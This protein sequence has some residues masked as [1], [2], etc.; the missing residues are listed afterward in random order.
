MTKIGALPII[1]LMV[2]SF[3]F[4]DPPD[5]KELY[6]RSLHS[7]K[8]TMAILRANNGYV[9]VVAD[10]CT[11]DFEEGADPGGGG[12]YV[13]LTFSY[14]WPPGTEWIM[15]YIDGTVRKNEGDTAEFTWDVTWD[16]WFPPCEGDEYDVSMPCADE[17]YVEAGTTIVIQWNNY[18]GVMIREELTP[19]SLGPIPGALEQ[20]RCKIVMKPVDGSCHSLGAAVYYDTQ[21]NGNDGA[22]ISTASGYVG[23][24]EIFYAPDIP[25][26]WRA[27]ETGYPPAPGSIVALGILVGFEA[28]MP[29]VF[30]YGPWR[31]AYGV[32]D[33]SHKLGWD[34]TG[35]QNMATDHE[36]FHD[37]TAVLVRWNERTVCPPDSVVFVTYYGI[38]GEL[39]TYVYFTH[40]PPEFT[41]HCSEI[42]PNPATLTFM[43]TNGSSTD[44]H[45]VCLDLSLPA[46]MT[47]VGGD[48]DPACFG[49]IAGYGGTQTVEWDVQ[50]DPSL[51]GTTVCY[52]VHLFYDEGPDSTATYCVDIPEPTSPVLTMPPDQ[53]IC[54]GECVGLTPTVS[55]GTPPYSFLWTPAEGLSC[56][57]CQYPNACPESTTTYQLIVTDAEGCA[58]TRTVTVYVSRAADIEFVYPFPCFGISTC[59]DQWAAALIESVTSLSAADT[60]YLWINDSLVAYPGDEISWHYSP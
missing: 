25:P 43:I 9:E 47:L 32:W 60:V 45:N 27:Y 6:A 56:T 40:T 11:G 41:A 26:V 37:D 18:M 54:E 16:C 36:G 4:A 12:S 3:L 39:E 14:A 21:L 38:E 49:S 59:E 19:Q 1:V 20:V 31:N 50:I 10:D 33:I 7:A 51:Y 13:D 35:W 29:D 52:D 46:G 48:S 42:S 44:A 55:E 28:T 15:F 34:L 24:S 58:D 57:D 2:L 23:H 8:S 53:Y 17:A 30:W 5:E 22:P